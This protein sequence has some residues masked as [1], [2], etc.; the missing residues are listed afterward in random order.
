MYV[1]GYFLT[2][3]FATSSSSYVCCYDSMTSYAS[4]HSIVLF[5]KFYFNFIVREKNS[6]YVIY[7]L[8]FFLMLLSHINDNIYCVWW[9]LSCRTVTDK[10]AKAQATKKKFMYMLLVH[11]FYVM[12][13]HTPKKRRGTK[14]PPE[15]WK[16]VDISF[17]FYVPHFLLFLFF[18]VLYVF[19]FLCYT[20]KA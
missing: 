7:D 6:I 18:C 14:N 4:V 19:F 20:A 3:F 8:C 16:N 2:L 13:T 10:R 5:F 11:I 17:I 9:K 1:F 12:N 15:M